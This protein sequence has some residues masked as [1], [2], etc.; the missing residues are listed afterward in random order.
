MIDLWCEAPN[1]LAPHVL[2][3]FPAKVF[4]SKEKNAPKPYSIYPKAEGSVEWPPFEIREIEHSLC[5]FDKHQRCLQGQGRPRQR[6][7]GRCE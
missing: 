6:F 7:A 4:K 1:Y 5:E 2:S 3:H